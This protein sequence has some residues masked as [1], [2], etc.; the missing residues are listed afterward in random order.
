MRTIDEECRTCGET[1]RSKVE[2]GETVLFCGECDVP[3][4]EYCK[5]KVEKGHFICADCFEKFDK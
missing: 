5:V 2:F 1:L 4:C 3:R